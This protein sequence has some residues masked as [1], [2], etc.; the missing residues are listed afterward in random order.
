MLDV[1]D[2]ILS[3]KST[4]IKMSSPPRQNGLNTKALVGV[5][6]L[7]G[8]VALIVALLALLVGMWIDGQSE[9]RGLAT[10]CLLVLSFP[11]NLSAMTFIA[12]KLLKR[13]NE[14]KR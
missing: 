9:Q 4:Y 13:M 8:A 5:G 12:F 1:C 6:V 2:K 11:V 14:S 3:R 10:V 7:V